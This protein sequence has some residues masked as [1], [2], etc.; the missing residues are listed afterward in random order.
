MKM[1]W[2]VYGVMSLITFLAFGIDKRRAKK[3][4]WRIK[5]ASLLLLGILGGALGALCGM[6]LFRHKTGHLAFWVVNLLALALQLA[7]ALI[8][9]GVFPFPMSSV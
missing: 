3:N 8:M 4:Q 5:E 9:T 2:I 1:I 7:L 6:R